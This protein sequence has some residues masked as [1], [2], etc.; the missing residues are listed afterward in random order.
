[1]SVSGLQTVSHLVTFVWTAVKVVLQ[2]TNPWQNNKLHCTGYH[3]Y[4]LNMTK[5]CDNISCK[6]VTLFCIYFWHAMSQH[7][8]LFWNVLFLFHNGWDNINWFIW[9]L[10]LGDSWLLSKPANVSARL[11]TGVATNVL[12]W[13]SPTLLTLRLSWVPEPWRMVVR[14]DAVS[15]Q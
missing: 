14:R 10:L 5:L 2:R 1:M 13:C 12:L 11:G 7:R 15:T 9:C 4:R 8:F 6:W 3:R